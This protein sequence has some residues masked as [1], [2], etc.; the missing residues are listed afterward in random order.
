ML[1]DRY[2]LPVSTGSAAARDAYAFSAFAVQRLLDAHG[3]FAMT[4]LLRD[5]G[6]GANFE[7]AFADRFQQ[8]FEEFDVSLR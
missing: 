4:S 3:G 2:D 8:P 5:L 1:A 6:S 7:A